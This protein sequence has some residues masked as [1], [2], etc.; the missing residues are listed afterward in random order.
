VIEKISYLLLCFQEYSYIFT[1]IVRL[2]FLLFSLSQALLLARC[3]EQ[4]A[5]SPVLDELARHEMLAQCERL[6]R[7]PRA[8]ALHASALQLRSHLERRERHALM[9]AVMQ[10]EELGARM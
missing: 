10:M 9:R 1:L 5:R 7:H 2:F 3:A 4:N 6:L 8:W